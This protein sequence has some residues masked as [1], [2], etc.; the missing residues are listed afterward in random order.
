MSTSLPAA[1]ASLFGLA[2]TALPGVQ[3]VDGELG[4]Y[5]AAEQFM[6]LD[7]TGND[8]V[9]T[10]GLP[11]QVAESYDIR[12]VV[13]AF[14]GDDDLPARRVRALAM[15]DAFRSAVAADPSLGMGDAAHA[16]ATRTYTLRAG[17]TEGGSAAQVEF[18]VAVTNV[19]QG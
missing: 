7:A 2:T 9:L 10:I 12:C 4:E 16:E 13:R 15:W 6:V 5:V 1:I 14:A 18:T 8:H 11:A 3:Q 17:M 19:T